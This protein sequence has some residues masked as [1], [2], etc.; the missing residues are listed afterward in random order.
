MKLKALTCS[1]FAAICMVI[2]P[3][4]S[5]AADTSLLSLD[6][7]DS[8]ELITSTDDLFSNIGVFMPGDVVSDTLK[9]ENKNSNSME[10]FFKSIPLSED[11]YELKEDYELLNRIGLKIEYNSKSIYD[12]SLIGTDLQNIISLGK[13]NSSE[14]GEFKFTLNFPSDLK[15]EFNMTQTKVKWYFAVTED[16]IPDSP[17]PPENSTPDSQTDSNTPNTPEISTQKPNTTTPNVSTTTAKNDNTPNTGLK[18]S[19]LGLGGIILSSAI[20]I[21]SKRKEK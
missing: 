4:S 12:G 21:L 2:S 19:A 5:N 1:L 20:A 9:I 3:I 15:N 8:K 11:N 10:L 18:V 6:Y 7:T 14:S 13:F 16:A 17:T